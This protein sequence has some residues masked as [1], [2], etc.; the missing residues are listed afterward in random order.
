MT[1]ADPIVDDDRPVLGVYVVWHPDCERA[2]GFARALF[3]T[4]CADPD[5]P[6]SR[7]L[8]IPVRFRTSNSA[9]ATPIPVPF[10]AAQ[11]TAVFVFA[12]DLLVADPSWCSYAEGLVQS[13]GP[14]GLV[15]PVAMTA[16]SNLPPSLASLQAIR[17]KEVPEE[18][19]ETVWLN[20][21]M[22]DVCRLLDP[23][24]AK[25]RVFLSHAKHDGLAITTTVRR[26]LRE[27]ARLDDFFDAADI[28]DGTR[29]AEFIRE[30]AGSLPALLAVQTDTYASREWC[31]LEVLEAKRC[32]VP[33]VVLAAVKGRE[34]RSFPYM[35]NVPVVRWQDETS[36][37][38]V[39]GALLGEVLRN[40]YFPK[41]VE[42]ICR[43]HGLHSDH[44]V[45]AYPPELLTVLA[46]RTDTL[47]SGGIV[48]RYLYPDP[49]LGTEEI[50][51]LRQLDDS[52]EPVTPT[53]LRAL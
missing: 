6:A 49:P 50:A 10:E 3:R 38:A 2:A 39:V 46:Y 17:L 33:I 34:T 28:P 12:D 42:A 36:L 53:M 44:Q 37:P 14:T 24:A 43:H 29:F 40:R 16:T 52:V 35:G 8:G 5:I 31:R 9:Q 47:A 22:H 18:Q 48:G 13:S 7:G 1:V 15:V 23:Q 41:R 51:L 21:A 32:R 30:R 27:V 26:H 45:F 4:L 25:V 19:Q 20:D 11:H